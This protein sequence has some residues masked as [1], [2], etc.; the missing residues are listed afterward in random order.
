MTCE[1]C[2]PDL[3][4]IAMALCHSAVRLDQSNRLELVQSRA[5]SVLLEPA[6]NLSKRHCAASG[7]ASPP[8]ATG[9]QGSTHFLS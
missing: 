6:P 9:S 5:G 7:F 8:T 4:E 1:V 3:W 2:S